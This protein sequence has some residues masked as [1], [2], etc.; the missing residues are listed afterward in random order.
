[1]DKELGSLKEIRKEYAQ[2]KALTYKPL[3]LR[4]KEKNRKAK[5]KLRNTGDV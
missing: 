5:L 2:E 4:N 1:M 3:S